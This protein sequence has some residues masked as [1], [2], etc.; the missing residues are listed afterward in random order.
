MGPNPY[1]HRI[2]YIE[3][4]GRTALVALEKVRKGSDLPQKRQ[5]MR[6]G[7]NRDTP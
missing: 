4:P 2:R 3:L 5:L 7:T 1:T 6:G